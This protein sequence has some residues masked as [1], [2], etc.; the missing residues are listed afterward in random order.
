MFMGRAPPRLQARASALPMKDLRTDPRAAAR[1]ASRIE[2]SDVGL[3]ID[4]R[5]VLQGLSFATAEARVGIVGRNGSGKSTLSRVIAGLVAPRTGQVRING[6]DPARDR[7]AAL[8]GSL[9]VVTEVALG[10]PVPGRFALDGLLMAGTLTLS[11]AVGT[12]FGAVRLTHAGLDPAAGGLTLNGPS[13]EDALH[14]ERCV[15]GPLALG[16]VETELRILQ[17]IVDGHG[18][19]AIQASAVNLTAEA[20]T[21]L[22]DTAIGEVFATDCLFDGALVAERTQA[23]CLQT[24]AYAPAG[25]RTPR[26]YR[27]QPDLA[28]AG[29]PAAEQAAIIAGLRPLF[30]STRFGDPNYGRLDDRAACELWTGA[31][32]GDAMGAWGLLN[33]GW[34]ETNL[35][36]AIEEYLPFGLAA[37][38]VYET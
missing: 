9:E 4:G 7:R 14:L 17:S 30:A 24:S 22:G 18:G 28:L 31:A 10:A 37:G 32:D 33:L 21:I 16:A 36:I 29:Q 6:H 15:C 27:C 5:A 12:A 11:G 23:G 20:A 25:S 34:R 19:P 13:I 26:R 3:S 35:R 1:T 38:S 8:V 2:L